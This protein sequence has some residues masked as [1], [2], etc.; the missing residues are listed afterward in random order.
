M[1]RVGVRP[2]LSQPISSCCFH[3]TRPHLYL[4]AGCRVLEYDLVSGDVLGSR[5]EELEVT[6]LHCS[7][8]QNAVVALLED[9]YVRV[10][11]E[12]ALHGGN[13]LRP[14]L[15]H[16][17]TRQ[18]KDQEKV[19]CSSL[20]QAS[21]AMFFFAKKGKSN[22]Y[23]LDAFADESV[24][25]IVKVRGAKKALKMEPTELVCHPSKPLF[26][27]ISEAAAIVGDSVEIRF[28]LEGGVGS[29]GLHSPS[30]HPTL[31]RMLAI[32]GYEILCWD[33]AS[34]QGFR[35][36]ASVQVAAPPEGV[37]FLPGISPYFCSLAI[38]KTTEPGWR[39]DVSCWYLDESE[40]QQ[41]LQQSAAMNSSTLSE[42]AAHYRGMQAQA[43]LKQLLFP[44]TV[45]P[46]VVAVGRTSFAVVRCIDR[47]CPTTVV[48]SAAASHLSLKHLE[49]ELAD[50][51]AVPPTEKLRFMNGGKVWTY[52]PA[53]HMCAV[54]KSD[55]TLASLTLSAKATVCCTLERQETSEGEYI[56]ATACMEF[57]GGTRAAF[58][59]IPGATTRP[60]NCKDAALVD[61]THWPGSQSPGYVAAVISEDGMSLSFEGKHTEA[62]GCAGPHLLGCPVSRVFSTPFCNGAALLFVDTANQVR[63]SRNRN[64]TC[65]EEGREVGVSGINWSDW[66]VWNSGPGLR[67]HGDENVI[68]ASWQEGSGL[69][70]DVWLPVLALLTSRRVVLLSSHLEVMAHAEVEPGYSS[71]LV[72]P[73]GI[74][75]G[76][77]FL[78]TTSAQI[79]WLALDGTT[80][81]LV[82]LQ[83]LN[84]T[85]CAVTQRDVTV[86][87]PDGHRSFVHSIPVGLYEPLALGWII[88]FKLGQVSLTKAVQHI[89]FRSKEPGS[90]WT[91]SASLLQ[92]IAE[93]SAT[94]TATTSRQAH[95]HDRDDEEAALQTLLQIGLEAAFDEKIGEQF[96]LETRLK[97]A[98]RCGAYRLG[99]EALRREWVNQSD[100]SLPPPLSGLGL[101][102]LLEQLA[103]V[104]R[105]AGE[106]DIERQ[107]RLLLGNQ[108]DPLHDPTG[109]MSMTALH[110]AATDEKPKRFAD[111]LGLQAR[112]L[113]S[114]IPLPLAE[115]GQ[116][117][118]MQNTSHM[119]STSTAPVEVRR[120][121]E[122][123]AGVRV[124]AHGVGGSRRRAEVADEDSLQLEMADDIGEEADPFDVTPGSALS[125][126]PA[127]R[128]DDVS[129]D[130][131][132]TDAVSSLRSAGWEIDRFSSSDEDDEE[133]VRVGRGRKI[134]IEIKQPSTTVSRSS[135]SAIL[136]GAT[137]VPL[138]TTDSAGNASA[139]SGFR[140]GAPPRTMSTLA[141]PP[142]TS[143]LNK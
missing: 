71:P 90:E 142:R 104:C 87:C 19:G 88:A 49:A 91:V 117:V 94:T 51:Q 119:P 20:S 80:G 45:L 93:I 100:P 36:L 12:L 83:S 50:D 27:A 31:S 76:V 35:L 43:T 11:K 133:D 139:R 28:A 132:S 58:F 96:P 38:D 131:V 137:S 17:C 44:H 64:A 16:R 59:Q 130:E 81:G 141:P 123:M 116:P 138:S 14:V 24:C 7:G 106:L 61:T 15:Q 75:C 125:G 63:F 85:L 6:S 46:I 98:L 21:R 1:H 9:R 41:P 136:E 72:V 82:S 67:L 47:V 32:R 70:G 127:H 52:E 74:W 102:G 128:Q 122:A 129:D 89:Q 115:V 92:A 39:V 113:P 107:C 97:I 126:S 2:S 135:V 68:S 37:Y 121:W 29:G 4:A 109:T 48:P 53:G 57:G 140:L 105:G 95:T 66:A 3:P 56:L 112:R 13:G 73:S 54:D 124:Q 23:A 25:E 10:Y 118:S 77:V 101:A 42:I 33:V 103:G 18:G 22:I 84:A 111:V 69:A 134:T 40:E 55:G 86:L 8:A 5:L 34:S 65:A 143:T 120:S 62:S 108:W 30:F 26:V 110:E 114:A 60:R 99:Y 78:Y 79:R